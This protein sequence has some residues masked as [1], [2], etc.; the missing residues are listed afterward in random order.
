M[1]LLKQKRTL[2]ILISLSLVFALGVV[3]SLAQEKIKLKD[4]RYWFVTKVE[5]I[6]VDDV[7]GHIIQILELKGVDVGTGD[8]AFN[9]MSM[10]LIKGNGTSQGYTTVTSPDGNN[11]RFFKIQGKSTSSLSPDGKPIS[12]S[13]GTATLIKGTGKWEGFQGGG[14]Y[15][16]KTIADGISIMDW[17]YEF[18]KK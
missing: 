10:D 16:A 7:E 6:K 4:R 12:M 5:V 14:T 9:K 3:T 11:A 8:V 18:T 13:E 2:V 15:K 17:E 1:K